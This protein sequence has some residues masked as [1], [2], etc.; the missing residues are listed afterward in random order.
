M[1]N[2][3][4]IKNIDDGKRVFSLCE[5]GEI[6]NGERQHFEILCGDSVFSLHRQTQNILAAFCLPVI[7]Q[8]IAKPARPSAYP[9]KYPIL[10]QD[11]FKS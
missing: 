7:D 11:T 5:E 4:I 2:Y 8:T 9:A 1:K 10:R 6:L 3:R